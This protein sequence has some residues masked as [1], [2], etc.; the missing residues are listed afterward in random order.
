MSKVIG[1]L[2]SNIMGDITSS[3]NCN[4]QRDPQNPHFVEE[5]ALGTQGY[6]L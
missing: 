2:V 3:K 1:S 4:T 6:I 5:S